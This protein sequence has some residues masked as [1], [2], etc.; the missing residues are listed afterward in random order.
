MSILLPPKRSRRKLCIFTILLEMRYISRWVFSPLLRASSE[1]VGF[2]GEGEASW[3]I[4][5]MMGEK[6]GWDEDQREL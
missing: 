3:R 5:M 1:L 2:P 4:W 6:T